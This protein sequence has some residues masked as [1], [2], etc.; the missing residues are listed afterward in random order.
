MSEKRTRL[1]LH[2]ERFEGPQPEKKT[3]EIAR[4]LSHVLGVSWSNLLER[5]LKALENGT[6]RRELFDETNEELV[7][8]RQINVIESLG[9]RAVYYFAWFNQQD[10]GMAKTTPSYPNKV[11]KVVGA[12]AN[13]Y[14]GSLDSIIANMQ[15]GSQLFQAASA[16]FKDG[17]LAVTDVFNYPESS[18]Y[19]AAL[20]AGFEPVLPQPAD[21]VFRIGEYK[22]P[23]IRM[24][25]EIGQIRASIKR[26]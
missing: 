4:R 11:L 6:V 17:K 22:L 3:L 13:C 19:Q 20:H 26:S 1:P 18:T 10:W 25:A 21:L 14:F 15:V 12:P 23:Q 7:R 8:A 24:S 2:I 5:E 9:H 16:P